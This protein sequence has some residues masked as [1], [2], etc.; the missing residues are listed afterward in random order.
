MPQ[1]KHTKI[2]ISGSGPDGYT[3]KYGRPIRI[4][5][6]LLA[7]GISAQLVLSLLMK[8]PKPGRTLDALQ[9]DKWPGNP[10]HIPSSFKVEFSRNETK[11]VLHQTL[12]IFRQSDLQYSQASRRREKTSLIITTNLSFGE[13][14]SV[15]GDA[16]MTTALLDRITHHCDILET[17]NDTYRFKQR[18]KSMKSA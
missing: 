14:V 7:T 2:Q 10:P 8:A 1:V 3:A 17:G 6:L 12:T 13:W 9:A 15:L 4:L 11:E 5:H 18:K 16:K